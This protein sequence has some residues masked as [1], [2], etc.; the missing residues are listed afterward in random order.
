MA[1]FFPNILMFAEAVG[2]YAD[3]SERLSRFRS[4][5]KE[6]DSL[7]SKIC[8]GYSQTRQNF[9]DLRQDAYIN[10]W[11]GLK[12][13]RGDS[14]LRTWLYRVTLNTYVSTLRKRSKYN[15]TVELTAMADLVDADCEQRQMLA[16]LYEAI[17]TLPPLDKAIIMM[18]LDEMSYEEIA[19][20]TDLGKNT[21]GTRIRRAKEKLK[22]DN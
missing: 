3:R 8:L 4:I 6:H 18:W 11:Q 13:F 7:I 5:L 9:E 1:Y 12:H 19:K 17:A 16:Q 14:Q 15:T 22:L 10:I 2:I 20:V 21:V